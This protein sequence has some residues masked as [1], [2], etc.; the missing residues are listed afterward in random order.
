[1]GKFLIILSEEYFSSTLVS[2]QL[3]YKIW[4]PIDKKYLFGCYIKMLYNV[5]G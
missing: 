3:Y 5:F 2:M 4:R 1:M